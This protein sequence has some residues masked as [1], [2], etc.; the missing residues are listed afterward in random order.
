MQSM[1]GAVYVCVKVLLLC[2]IQLGRVISKICLVKLF[3]CF[4]LVFCASS[5]PLLFPV[6]GALNARFLVVST[7]LP[8]LLLLFRSDTTGVFYGVV[9]VC[10]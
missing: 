7:E 9:F 5:V 10:V 1:G 2:T 3:V 4:C 6:R 8:S